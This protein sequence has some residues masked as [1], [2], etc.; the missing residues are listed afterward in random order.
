MNK[1]CDCFIGFLSGEEI[2]K[3][4]LKEKVDRIVELQPKF[5][6]IGLLKGEP[7]TA[8]QIVDG[9]KGY[10]SRFSFC[11]YCGQ[12]INWKEIINENF[13]Q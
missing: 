10:L 2:N 13:K 7:N 6:K 8:I 12:K 11:P 1:N 4:T 9:R 5:K 3:S